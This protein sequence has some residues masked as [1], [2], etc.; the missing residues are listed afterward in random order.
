MCGYLIDII[1]EINHSLEAPIIAIIYP[2]KAQSEDDFEPM[3]P[4]D[5]K[6][7]HYRFKDHTSSKIHYDSVDETKGPSPLKPN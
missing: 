4:T 3:H 1:P 5:Q 2:R 7:T 6:Y